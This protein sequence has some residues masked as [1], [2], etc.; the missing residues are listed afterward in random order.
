MPFAGLLVP[1]LLNM[2]P[3]IL[4]QIEKIVDVKIENDKTSINIRKIDI[5]KGH[6][7]LKDFQAVLKSKGLDSIPCEA[8]PNIAYKDCDESEVVEISPIGR[9]KP[10]ETIHLY[11]VTSEVIEKSKRMYDDEIRRQQENNQKK[12]EQWDALKRATNDAAVKVHEASAD[13]KG[14]V[15]DMF[16]KL[17]SPPWQNKSVDAK[18]GVS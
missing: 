10:N 12:A 5:S 6:V 7:S 3:S 17:P 14:K 4:K 9:I 18:D 13:A 1:A 15:M 8:T 11:Y 2:M 16:D